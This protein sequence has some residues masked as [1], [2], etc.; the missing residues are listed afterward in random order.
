MDQICKRLNELNRDNNNKNPKTPKCYKV[1][2]NAFLS[3]QL[4]AALAALSTK[5]HN[6]ETIAEEQAMPKVRDLAACGCHQC[7]QTKVQLSGEISE[8][9]Q[10]MMSLAQALSELETK[11]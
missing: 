7:R 2:A 9:G 4:V 3:N 8:L 10:S 6:L 1:E 5:M 11:L